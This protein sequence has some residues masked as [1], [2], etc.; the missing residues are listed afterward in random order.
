MG[1]AVEMLKGSS[2]V[3]LLLCGTYIRFFHRSRAEVEAE[4]HVLAGYGVGS[5][6]LLC[7]A[8]NRVLS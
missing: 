8:F 6:D 1:N 5:F 4:S 3:H 7:F 2:F